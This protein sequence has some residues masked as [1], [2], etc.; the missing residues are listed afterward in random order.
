MFKKLISVIC[1]CFFSFGYYAQ[2]TFVP[3]NSF[4]L[5]IETYIPGASNGNTNDN[6]VNTLAIQNTTILSFSPSL[7]PSGVINDFTGLEAFSSLN[8]MGIQYMNMTNVDLSILFVLSSGALFDFQLAIQNTNMLENLILPQGGGIKLNIS[9]CISLNNIVFHSNNVLESQSTISSCP[10]LK[11]FDISMVSFVKLQSSIWLANNSNLQCVNLKNGYCGNW[12]SVGITGSSNVTCVEVDNPTYCYTASGTTWNTEPSIS[13]STG[14]NCQVGITQFELSN[15]SFSPNP[16]S[17]SLTIKSE[18]MKN[19]SFIIYDQ[20]GRT[21]IL[22]QLNGI[23]TEVNLSSLSK[24]MY[25]LKIEGN[26]QPAQIV[27]E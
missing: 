18:Q 13:Y 4:E 14:C 10:S 7:V 5:Y 6:Y 19:E 23:S 1:I 20:L 26:Y 3:D 15:F 22:G 17:N 9:S 11:N 21:V 16:T 24:G 2:L 27:K 12:S 8:T 25:T